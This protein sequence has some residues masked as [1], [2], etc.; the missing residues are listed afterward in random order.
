M[1]L[2]DTA[3]NAMAIVRFICD[4][5]LLPPL[6]DT[7][8]GYLTS[9]S[10][11]SGE[12][13]SVESTVLC[14]FVHCVDI[15]NGHTYSGVLFSTFCSLWKGR[16]VVFRRGG[17]VIESVFRTDDVAASDRLESWREHLSQTHAPIRIIQ[18]SSV[19]CHAVQRV[20]LLGEVVISTSQHS[21]MMIERPKNLIRCSDPELFYLALPLCGIIKADQVGRATVH[22]GGDFVLHDTSH[23]LAV[24]TT[25]EPGQEQY[26]G[27]AVQIPKALLPLAS[28]DAER[29]F[30]RHLPANEGVGALLAQTLVQISADAGT[31]QPADALRL[32]TVVGDLI[33]ALFAHVL[34]TGRSLA[35]EARQRT[36][37]L[38]VKDFIQR[39]L[40]DPALTPGRVAAAH[41][42]STSYLHR[43]FEGEEVTVGALIRRQRLE[44]VCRDLAD[45]ALRGTTIQVI[46]ARWG[47]PRAAD[48]SRAFRSAYGVPASDYRHQALHS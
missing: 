34:D 31:Y 1:A 37:A 36:L 8:N 44:R 25:M 3:L 24:E 42:I 15:A 20:L 28:V 35:A 33:A 12:R 13:L 39:H 19:E 22:R 17:E 10:R 5:L 38:H 27:V 6:A 14:H 4:S 16:V 30:A 43:I 21:P 46:A 40:A 41:H 9:F 2:S 32:S 26:R 48:F 45:P 11:F 7:V 18:I 29:L 23:P 47:F